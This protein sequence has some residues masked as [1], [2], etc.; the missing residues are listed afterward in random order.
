MPIKIGTAGWSIAKAEAHKF[1]VSGSGLQRYASRF[2]IVEINSSFHR[3][4]LPETW[5]RWSDETPDAFR[6]AVKLPK[7]I[8]HTRKLRDCSNLVG[9]FLGEVAHLG[10]KLGAVLV[11]LPPKLEFNSVMCSDVFD[12]LRTAVD[13]A[14]VC[15]PRHPSW[16][17]P[18]VDDFLLAHRVCRAAADPAIMPSAAVPGGSDDLA[19]F[20]LHGSPVIYR[21]SYA[22]RIE[23]IG[24]TLLAT[25]AKS[26]DVWCVFDNTASSDATQNALAVLQVIARST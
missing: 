7:E 2:P 3:S 6:F 15:E 10:P 19:Y 8:T 18:R 22:D 1:E 12:Q 5:S 17:T 24:E 20:R 21:S 23:K 16:F 9:E 13:A 11:Q 14:I 25:S 4:H 26:N